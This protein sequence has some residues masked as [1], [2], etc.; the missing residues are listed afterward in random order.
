MLFVVN[1][2]VVVVAVAEA[3]TIDIPFPVSSF[4]FFSTYLR[5]FWLIFVDF[6]LHLFIFDCLGDLG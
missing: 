2:N 5:L 6:G 3:V 1:V 4:I